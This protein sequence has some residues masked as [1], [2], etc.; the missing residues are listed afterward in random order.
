MKYKD[1]YEALGVKPAATLDEIK[2]AYRKLA[3]QYHPDVSKDPQGEEKFKEVAEAYS[4]LKD[5]EKRAA[6]DELGKHPAGQEFRP[7]PNWGQQSAGQGFKAGN[8]HGFSF[9]DLDFSDLFSSFSGGKQQGQRSSA[10]GQDYELSTDISLEDAYEGATVELNFV[11]QEQDQQGQIQRVPHTFKTRIPKGVTN[12]QKLLLRG[13]GGKGSNGGR[14]GNLYLT[15]NFL[16]HHLFHANNHDLL[17]DL[18]LS[19][20]EAA[21]GATVRVPTLSGAVNLK[22]PAGSSSGQKLR[23]AKRGLP[24]KNEEFGDLFAIIQIVLPTTLSE[25]EQVLLKE[26]SQTSTFNPRSH[27]E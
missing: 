25:Q 12:G 19:P 15:I 6:Y 8:S 21:L 11:V 17:I 14:D 26:L 16:K 1:Y 18:P 4:T 24:K 22:I 13:K 7:P 9:D 5:P 27:F 20:W 23:I 2:K 3:H 10:A